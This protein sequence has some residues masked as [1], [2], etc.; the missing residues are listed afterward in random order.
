MRQL[1]VSRFPMNAGYHIWNIEIESEG[2][3][4]NVETPRFGI[5]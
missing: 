4:R 3:E 1:G 5:L 2:K